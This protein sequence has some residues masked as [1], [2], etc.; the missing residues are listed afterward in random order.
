MQQGAP[1]PAPPVCDVSGRLPFL[2]SCDSDGEGGEERRGEERK[3]VGT[4]FARHVCVVWRAVRAR[5]P[6]A[7]TIAQKWREIRQEASSPTRYGIR[8]YFSESLGELKSKG[9]I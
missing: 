5:E 1:L 6:K 3:H 4:A 2:V 9:E 8:H 7:A